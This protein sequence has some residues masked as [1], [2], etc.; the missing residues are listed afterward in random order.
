MYNRLMKIDYELLKNPTS[1]LRG[2]PFWAWN[3]E[4][5]EKEIDFQ[6][7][8]LKKMG[9]GGAFIHSRTGLKTEYMGEKWLKLVRH[10]AEKLAEHRLEA[11]LYDEDRWPS[12][13][14][15]GYVT[16]TKEFRAKYMTYFE[17]ECG[18]NPESNGNNGKFEKPENNGNFEKPE[19]F[20][21]L[22][23]VEFCGEA[24]KNYRKIAAPDEKKENER[25]FVFYF[26]YMQPDS[27]YN[28]YTYADTM[29]RAAT[30]RFIEL[31]HEK[32]FE[33]F[34]ELFGTVIKGIFTDE[35]H[36]NPFLNGFSRNEKNAER[37]IPYTYKLFVEFEKR[38]GYKIE[39]RLP[40][41]WFGDAENDFCKETYDLIEVEQ[42]LFLENF[43]VPYHD[44]CRAHGLLVTGH[45]LHEDNLA[46]QTTMCGSVMR[47]YEYM[48]YPGM[49]NLCEDNFAV[50]VPSLVNS[51]AK[52]LGKK[53]VLD[54]LYA[55][56]GW[57]MTLADYKR[58]GNWQSFGGI[59]LRCPHLSWYTMKGQAK[60]D[61]PASILHQSAWYPEHKYLE[62]Y[63]SR[64]QYLLTFGE[65]RTDVAIINP[66][67]SL[68]GLTNERSYV[69]YFGTTSPLISR[70]ER[71]YYGLFKFL[72]LNGGAADYIDEGIFAKYGKAENGRLVVGKKRYDKIIL[73]GNYNLRSTTLS[74][75]S[76]F[77]RGGG[78]LILAGELPRY[79]DGIR[80]DFSEDLKGAVNTGF[81]PEKVLK[82][83]KSDEV[84]VSA[85]NI[86]SETRIFDDG[87]M[88][89]F[90]NKSD[91]AKTDNAVSGGNRANIIIKNA[92]DPVGINLYT[93]E[94]FFVPFTRRGDEIIIERNFENDGAL[95][96]LC[97]GEK[98]KEKKIIEE[99][100]DFPEEF[101]YKLEEPNVLPL[102]FADCYL[103][104][105]FFARGDVLDIDRKIRE[106]FGLEQRH[107]EMVQP[108][109]KDKFYPAPANLCKIVLKYSFAAAEPLRGVSFMTE[110]ENAE[111]KVNG[112]LLDG[113]TWRGTKTDSCFRL[114]PIADEFLKVGKNEITVAFGF[115]ER[116]DIEGAFLCGNF[117]VYGNGENEALKN[118]PKKLN[119][120]DF[121]VQGLKYYGGRISLRSPLKN[122]VYRLIAEDLP[123]AACIV[124][125][126]PAVFPPINAEFEVTNGELLITL[127]FTRQNT[128]GTEFKN[129][130][131][132]GLIPQGLSE[133]TSLV[134]IG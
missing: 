97:N 38:K 81:N 75:L 103:D 25:V 19:N 22:F 90:L 114:I 109:F 101:D 12:G 84:T 88:Y 130:V 117:G 107:G 100:T 106:K 13:T 70:L 126:V 51:V 57:K 21:G 79:L 31:T 122:G 16:E 59:S 24:A 73:N 43:A 20:L 36:R 83:I 110:D 82:L 87:K 95:V 99:P 78:T 62:D 108:W 123:C 121:T 44:W 131:R 92:S 58:T 72:R 116:Y 134:L 119:P 37:E 132:S 10:A 55:A 35:P 54:E 96:L 65:E 27:F 2:K 28:G 39:E 93:S 80:H 67:E 46:A 71:E 30:E 118:L 48:D 1:E 40:L 74:A 29:N 14:C 89:F 3:G 86:I 18:E 91:S 5:E 112:N 47:Y 94:K 41:L 105:E 49:D 32:Y 52:Q 64:L 124:N 133:K 120:G 42:E 56:T 7:E 115:N 11:Y 17:V 9:F 61:Y 63:F 50:N 111:I 129:G 113:K 98:I 128:F 23:A 76:E 6:I 33:A 66:V 53:F 34:G 45:V 69:N 4:I 68:W 102:D 85:E 104:G 77:V 60:R 15:G 26:D 127:A 8:C 125:D